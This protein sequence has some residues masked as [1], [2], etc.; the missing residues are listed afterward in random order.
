M[1]NMAFSPDCVDSYT[2]CLLIHFNSN[3]CSKGIIKE[4][5]E[6]ENPEKSRQ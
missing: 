4:T 5:E 2:G 1:C 6:A 3:I